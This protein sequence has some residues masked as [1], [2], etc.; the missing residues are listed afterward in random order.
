MNKYEFLEKLR[1][2]LTGLPQEDINERTCFYSEMIDDLL[3]E[4]LSEAEAVERIGS[5]EDIISQI[6]S[7]TP[8][9]KIVKEKVKERRSLSILEIILLVLSA[10]IWLS[11]LASAFS[12]VISVYI[13]VWAVIIVLW[14]I[15][16]ALWACAFAGIVSGV[17]FMCQSHVIAGCAML[18]WGI[19]LVGVS[20]FGVFGCNAVP[21]AVVYITK[22]A[23]FLIKSLFIGKER[24][25]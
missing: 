6:I 14:A 7:E 25:K 21:K 5:V 9:Q 15:V 10:P 2:G 4:G 17:V 3:E 12:V 8:L 1:A 24:T 19:F 22:K 13:T 20:I 23:V 11:L 18:G 16:G